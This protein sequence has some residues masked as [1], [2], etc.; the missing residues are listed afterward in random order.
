MGG[1]AVQAR[2][3]DFAD[4]VEAGGLIIDRGKAHQGF[5]RR[6]LLDQ[7][8]AFVRQVAGEARAAADEL[9]ARAVERGQPLRNRAILHAV[10]DAQHLH[11]TAVPVRERT[12]VVARG[13][14]LV[15]ALEPLRWRL[16]E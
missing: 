5:L 1:A 2:A 4:V 10:D 8:R 16:V 3:G 15:H 11:L 13:E 14:C 9:P 6:A 12:V 7:H